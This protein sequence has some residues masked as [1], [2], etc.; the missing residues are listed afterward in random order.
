MDLFFVFSL[1]K[2]RQVAASNLNEDSVL[3][4]FEDVSYSYRGKTA[5]QEINL[6]LHAGRS[7][8]IL[9]PNGSGKSTLIDLFAGLKKPDKGQISFLGA[10]IDSYSR[11]ALALKLAL[12]PQ[13]FRLQ[14]DFSVQEVVEMGLHPHLHR[15]AFPGAADLAEVSEALAKTDLRA[16]AKRSIKQLSGGEQQRVALARALVQKP[17]VLLLDEATSNL[18]IRHTL[19]FLQFVKKRSQAGNLNVVAVMHDLNL[20]ALFCDELLFLKEGR[21]LAHGP[22]AEILRPDILQMVYNVE[23]TVQHNEFTQSQQVSLRLT[24]KI[25]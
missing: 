14:F 13:N 1:K 20:A 21:L 15:F 5:L 7:Y 3:W 12:V 19:A 24:D 6:C 8:G 9:G 22:V 18:D 10:P 2:G 17:Q 4:Q 23:A 11:R 25:I 16:L